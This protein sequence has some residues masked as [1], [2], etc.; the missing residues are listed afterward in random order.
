LGNMV[1][2]NRAERTCRDPDRH[3]YA[4]GNSDS[5]ANPNTE[6]EAHTE[7]KAN[8]QADANPHP[9]RNADRNHPFGVPVAPVGRNF[10]KDLD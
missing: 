8:S 5:Y 2:E 3:G 7:A 10:A 6:A 9:D 4:H 1:G